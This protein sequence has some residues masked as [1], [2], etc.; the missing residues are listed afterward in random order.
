MVLLLYLLPDHI[1]D[2][3]H[4][5]LFSDGG[6]SGSIWYDENTGEAVGLHV[7]GDNSKYSLLE[8]GGNQ[9]SAIACHITEVFA[10]L[11]IDLPP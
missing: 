4:L 9:N 2:P 6:D 1:A 11:E 5:D 3:G 10:R 7:A 8:A